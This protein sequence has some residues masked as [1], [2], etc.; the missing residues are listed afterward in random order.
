MRV[1]VL[2]VPTSDGTDIRGSELA[3]RKL[4]ELGLDRVIGEFWPFNDHGDITESVVE[5]TDKSENLTNTKIFNYS[6][7]IDFNRRLAEKAAAMTGEEDFTLFLG[8][9]HSLSAATLAGIL[10]RYPDTAVVWMD[11]HGDLNTD[12]TTPSHKAHGMPCAALLGFGDLALRGG[13]QDLPVLKSDRLFLLCQRQSALDSGETDLIKQEGLYIKTWADI[14]RIGVVNVVEDILE[15]CRKQ[16]VKRLHLSFD[17]DALDSSLVPGTGTPVEG[18]PDATNVSIMLR[19][20]AGSGMLR[21]MDFVE[22]NP[23]LDI[24]DVTAKLS[25]SLLGEIFRFLR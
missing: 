4:R 20:I 1:A 8:G 18:G 19:A 10:S 2:G 13:L 17:I 24:N 14:K 7:V 3:P 11:A 22:L 5:H 16:K 15:R 12:D 6:R 9:D 23:V 21:S 25:L